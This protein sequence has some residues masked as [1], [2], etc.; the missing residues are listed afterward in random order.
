MPE[1]ASTRLGLIGPSTTDAIALGDDQIRAIIAQLELV[2]AAFQQGT[3]RPAASSA[4]QGRFYIHTGTGVLS[5]CTGSVWID[6][7]PASAL[8][9][10]EIGYDQITSPVAVTSGT[11][12][13]GTTILTATAHTFDG[14]PV[15]VEFFSP[16][17]YADSTT[18]TI[19]LFEGATQI[20]RLGRVQ[21]DPTDGPD[22]SRAFVGR[23]RFTPSAGAHTYKVTGH[24]AGAEDCGVAAGAG[25]AA[26]DPPAFL[27]FTKV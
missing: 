9:G 5:Y 14:A 4:M 26:T 19:S 13:T 27:R 15:M 2:G 18:L 17:T 21:Q 23:L 22:F 11:E 25:G 12:A 24:R 10:Y 1:A 16:A 3:S 8:P 6:Y 7:T 20:A